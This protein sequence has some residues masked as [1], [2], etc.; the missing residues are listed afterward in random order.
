MEDN[1]YKKIDVTIDTEEIAQ[2]FFDELTK[3]GF[4]PNEDELGE[5][6]DITFEYLVHK[7]IVEEESE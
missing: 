6:A 3:R 5:I 2:F 7:N 4:I 1:E